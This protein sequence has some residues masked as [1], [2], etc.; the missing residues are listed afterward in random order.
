MKVV[1]GGLKPIYVRI[2]DSIGG[3]MVLE[4]EVS[5][6]LVRVECYEMGSMRLFFRR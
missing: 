6:L 4:K 2:R 5:A 1:G 3:S